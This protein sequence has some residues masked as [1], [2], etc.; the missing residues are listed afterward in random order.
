LVALAV[1][2]SVAITGP[3]AG[4]Q[5]VPPP[6]ADADILPCQD[7]SI[8]VDE[9]IREM[10]DRCP[11]GC[12]VGVP[13][14]SVPNVLATGDK[15]GT[16]EPEYVHAFLCAA[17]VSSTAQCLVDAGAQDVHYCNNCW[18]PSSS[19]NSIDVKHSYDQNSGAYLGAGT[20][21]LCTV[22]LG[23][24]SNSVYDEDCGSDSAVSSLPGNRDTMLNGRIWNA[25]NHDHH[26]DAHAYY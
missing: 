6:T 19:Y 18:L 12:D 15:D 22:L 3:T 8:P 1:L 11:D 25:G 2:S 26:F 24:Y 7:F 4:A 21:Y 16:S 5:D 14:H 23:W 17:A 10:G 20:A 13:Q 9:C